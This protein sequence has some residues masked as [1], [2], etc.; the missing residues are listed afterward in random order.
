MTEL[1]KTPLNA[2]H[3]ESGA[4][5]VAFAGWDMPLHYGSQLEEHQRT[6][7]DSSMFDVSHMQVLDL[8]GSQAGDFLRYL[9]ANDV[10]RLQEPG[11][12]VYSCMLD[13]SGGV[14]DDL[15][16]YALPQGVYRLV[17]N[18]GTADKD[19]AWIAQQ[20]ERRGDDCRVRRR[21]DL[22]LIAVQGPRARERTLAA[23]PQAAIAADVARFHAAGDADLWIARTGYTGEDGYEIM[24]RAADAE[25]WWRALAGRG[26]APAGLGARDTLRLEAGLNLYG[27]DMDESV[28][29]MEAGLAWTVDL[30]SERDFI[31][32]RA[33]LDHQPHCAFFG[34]VL[35]DKG[36]MRTHQAVRTAQG[37]GR[38]TSG[39]Y[40]P[41]VRAS[42]GLARLPP[43]VKPGD[44][45]EVEIRE[46]WLRARIVRPP[47]VRNG[48]VLIAG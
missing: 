14:L 21:D 36:I 10:A 5:M 24:L 23:C 34:I 40:G 20:R 32:K 18:A 4:R 42:I 27:A 13:A 44:A 38:L 11:S 15:I 45:A 48:R 33:L 30:A 43:G 26:V 6:R 3:R 35:E 17:V 2:V 41:T 37:N 47:F 16:V 19:V 9:L 28:T 39:G 1:R 22:A 29:P 31:G 25:S 12:A 7:A 8:A 46:R